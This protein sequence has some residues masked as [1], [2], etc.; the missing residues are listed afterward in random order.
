MSTASRVPR[1]ST[2]SVPGDTLLAIL[3][4]G[5]MIKARMSTAPTSLEITV[6]PRSF[7]A[8]TH[9]RGCSTTTS[10][11]SPTGPHGS[12]T[13][14]PTPPGAAYRGDPGPGGRRA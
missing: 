13:A 9:A 12:A 6:V 14:N 3:S 1:I 5:S 10:P 4:R 7:T 8:S 11:P 2:N